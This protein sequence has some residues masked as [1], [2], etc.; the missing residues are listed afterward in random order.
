MYNENMIGEVMIYGKRI[1][2]L[3]EE[4][5][6]T[7]TELG[8]IIGVTKAS[9]CCYEK[10]TRVP[11]IENLVDLSSFFDVSLDYLVG[12]NELDIVSLG[13]KNFLKLLKKDKK[14]YSKIIFEPEKYIDFLKEAVK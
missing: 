10:G 13:E 7:Q 9:I 5:G 14:L 11:T 6:L 4:R 12:R 2:K 8:N 3:R 1:K